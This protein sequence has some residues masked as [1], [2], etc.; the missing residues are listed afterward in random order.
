MGRDLRPRRDAQ[1]SA[2]GGH[3]AEDRRMIA[4]APTRNDTLSAASASTNGRV[5]EARQ[6]A[7]TMHTPAAIA[8]SSGR[9]LEKQE[10]RE[11]GEAGLYPTGRGRHVPGRRCGEVRACRRWPSAPPEPRRASPRRRKQRP[12]NSAAAS[13]YPSHAR[14]AEDD[15]A[16]GDPAIKRLEP[17]RRWRA[18][19]IAPHEDAVRDR[20]NSSQ[21]SPT[22]RRCGRCGDDATSGRAKNRQQETPRTFCSRREYRQRARAPGMAARPQRSTSAAPCSTQERGANREACNCGRRPVAATAD[23][24][25][26]RGGSG[27]I[28]VASAGSQ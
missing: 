18:E 26:R 24:V 28:A 19:P 21:S 20:W 10:R 8:G 1:R 27:L 9:W 15:G 3:A 25:R 2:S 7:S 22:L 14:V 12:V 4:N 13:R 17:E 23:H 5:V 16:A 11:V 6:N